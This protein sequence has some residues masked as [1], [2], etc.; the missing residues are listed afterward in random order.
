MELDKISIELIFMWIVNIFLI[1]I[2]V[3]IILSYILYIN[4]DMELREYLKTL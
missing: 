3:Y 2:I 1:I 4:S